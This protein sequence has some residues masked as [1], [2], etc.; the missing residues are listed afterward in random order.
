MNPSI[1]IIPQSLTHQSLPE[2][3]A[4]APERSWP[5]Q[6]GGKKYNKIIA[7]YNYTQKVLG[8]GD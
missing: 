2:K 1:I 4:G 7:G 6:C 5:A 8:L 3:N